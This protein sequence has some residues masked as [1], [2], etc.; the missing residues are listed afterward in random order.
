ML[1]NNFSEYYEEHG[2]QLPINVIIETQIGN[3]RRLIRLCAAD[4]D[5]ERFYS[6]FYYD[7]GNACFLRMSE[8]D[9][10]SGKAQLTMFHELFPEPTYS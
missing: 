3:R 2:Y 8:K 6:G 5:Q 9:I 7:D 1:G 10:L 4:T